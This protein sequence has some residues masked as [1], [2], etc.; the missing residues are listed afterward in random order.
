MD[1]PT[2][3]AMWRVDGPR[4]ERLHPVAMPTEQL[5]EDLIEQDPDILGI[6]LLIIGRQVVT[7][8]GGRI[9]LLAADGDGVLH[10]LEL[11]KARTAREVL[12]QA[13]DYGSWVR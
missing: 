5:L 6:R 13:L 1:M 3:I 10:V 2:E 4:A 8:H 7:P 9:D 11:K 12:A